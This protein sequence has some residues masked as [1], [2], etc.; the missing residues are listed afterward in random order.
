MPTISLRLKKYIKLYEN[1]NLEN[2]IQHSNININLLI[3]YLH[4][5]NK[6]KH[7]HKKKQSKTL[8]LQK[9]QTTFKP[10]Y[11][12][13]TQW[14]QLETCRYFHLTFFSTYWKKLWT[15][16]R[17]KFFSNSRSILHQ[18]FQN[19]FTSV[20]FSNNIGFKNSE[21]CRRFA[22]IFK[23]VKAFLKHYPMRGSMKKIIEISVGKFQIP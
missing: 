2:G 15:I 17:F 20:N 9:F 19:F 7:E 1:S 5:K 11:W 4:L 10:K 22:T 16:K 3:N 23:A 12:I 8:F 14:Q 13:A 21:F 6:K 18:T